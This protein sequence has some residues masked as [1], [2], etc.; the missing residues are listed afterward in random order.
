MEF[1]CPEASQE[2]VDNYGWVSGLIQ[3]CHRVRDGIY[4]P[5]KVPLSVPEQVTAK[6]RQFRRLSHNHLCCMLPSEIF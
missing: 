6:Q 5:F 4:D 3:L 1:Q 2:M